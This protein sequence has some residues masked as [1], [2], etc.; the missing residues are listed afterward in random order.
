MPAARGRRS[1]MP[2]PHRRRR[3]LRA[4][5]AEALEARVL[6]S[7]IVWDNRGSS[8][9]D[10]DN[11]TSTFHGDAERAREVV[12][13]ALH[14]WERVISNFNY[15]GGSN[16]YHILIGMDAGGTRSGGSSA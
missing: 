4:A 2:S 7:D 6:S 9:H 16:V 3:R 13:A 8:V 10:S 11:F 5:L 12:D 15:V 1:F 14:T